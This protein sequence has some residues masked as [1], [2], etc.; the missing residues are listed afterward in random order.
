[1]TEWKD[2]LADSGQ[3]SAGNMSSKDAGNFMFSSEPFGSS[4]NVVEIQDFLRSDGDMELGGEMTTLEVGQ[5]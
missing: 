1:M 4:P 5:F 2:P 3:S